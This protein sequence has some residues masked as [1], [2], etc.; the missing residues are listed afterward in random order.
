MRLLSVF[1]FVL[2]NSAMPASAKT[3]QRPVTYTLDDITYEGV[4]IHDDAVKS[5]RPGLLL[6][7]NWLGLT[8]QNLEQAALV[9]GNRYVVFVVDLYGKNARPKDTTDAGKLAGALKADRAE[10]RKRMHKALEV[11][12][13]Q[14]AGVDQAH[15]GAVGFCFGGTAV[16]ELGKSGADV[17]GVVSIHGGLDAPVQTT[18]RPKAAFLALHGADD[19]TVTPAQLQAFEDDLRKVG[20][21]WTLVSYGKAVHSFTDPDANVPGRS[22]YNPLVARRAYQSMNDF[23][24]E[25]FAGR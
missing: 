8:P 6:V 11:F 18:T 23:F 5:P 15:V 24:A 22:M 14:K 10:L 21:D 1:L 25:L 13:A 17:K 7:P 4:L 3:V 19:P 12:R 9:A 16:N 20:A 2:V